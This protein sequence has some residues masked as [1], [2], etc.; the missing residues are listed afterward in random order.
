MGGR[1]CSLKRVTLSIKQAKQKSFWQKEEHVQIPK[2]EKRN[3]KKSLLMDQKEGQNGKITVRKAVRES[4]S[5]DHVEQVDPGQE[6]G[7]CSK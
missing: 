4:I 6:F 3:H 5:L 1:E 7:F 2:M